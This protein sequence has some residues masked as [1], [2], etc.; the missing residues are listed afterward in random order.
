MKT[1]VNLK[2]KIYIG[3]TVV[4]EWRIHSRV[5][6]CTVRSLLAPWY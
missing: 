3:K 5:N 1:L 6:C 2:K 4:L